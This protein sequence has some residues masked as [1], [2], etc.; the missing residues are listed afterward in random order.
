MEEWGGI[1][2]ALSAFEA[3]APDGWELLPIIKVGEDLRGRAND[4]LRGVGRI[5][6]SPTATH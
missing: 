4:Y 5:A 3:R 2:Y 6:P 1:C